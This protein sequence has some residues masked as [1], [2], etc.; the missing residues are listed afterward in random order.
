MLGWT[1]DSDDELYLLASSSGTLNLT[2]GQP[3]GV[4]LKLTK[5][6]GGKDDEKDD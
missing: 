6:G 3:A 2:N 5:V 1:P 4:V